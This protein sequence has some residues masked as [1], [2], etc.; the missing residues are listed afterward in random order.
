M[1]FAAIKVFFD[2]SVPYGLPFDEAGAARET[3]S[4]V[5][6]SEE[7]ASSGPAGM[8]SNLSGPA[9]GRE[10][11]RPGARTQLT[12]RSDRKRPQRR[13]RADKDDDSEAV[14][15][16]VSE[17][18]ANRLPESQSAPRPQ[19]ALAPVSSAAES[20]ANA[21]SETPSGQDN[22]ISLDRF[23]KKP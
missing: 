5:G 11:G 13:S 6:I 8:A 9:I 14:A 19:P 22:V 17:N 20:E 16:R 21:T 3:G 4:V 1:P 12:D 15:E 18:A 2:P 10:G 7:I 23:R